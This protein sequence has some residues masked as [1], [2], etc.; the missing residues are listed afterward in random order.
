MVCDFPDM[1]PDDL[2]GLLL[3]WEI[4]FAI[5]FASITA[6]LKELKV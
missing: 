2:S 3:E 6:E 4:A 5:D 1:F